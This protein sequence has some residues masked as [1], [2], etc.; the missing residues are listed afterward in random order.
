MEIGTAYSTP[1]ALALN[2]TFPTPP[3]ALSKA[4]IA[5][6]AQYARA[7]TGSGPRRW[8]RVK[9]WKLRWGKWELVDVVQHEQNVM[10]ERRLV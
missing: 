3:P 4:T 5:R 10:P 1:K 8:N 6:R 7:Q 9:V 2:L